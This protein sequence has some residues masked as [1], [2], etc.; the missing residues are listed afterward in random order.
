MVLCLRV[1]FLVAQI[2]PLVASVLR[3]HGEISHGN[4]QNPSSKA[5]QGP[6]HGKVETVRFSL[7]V[8]PAGPCLAAA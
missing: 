2:T 4:P 6:L 3:V 7:D 8:E 1:V 5:A